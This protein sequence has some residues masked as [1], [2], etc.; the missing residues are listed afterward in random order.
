MTKSTKYLRDVC[1]EVQFKTNVADIMNRHF[2]ISDNGDW[3]GEWEIIGG[4]DSDY[5]LYFYEYNVEQNKLYLQGRDDGENNKYLINELLAIFKNAI[6]QISFS[7]SF[8]D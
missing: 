5:K 1:L 2:I 8:S 4:L 3:Y 7:N 6:S